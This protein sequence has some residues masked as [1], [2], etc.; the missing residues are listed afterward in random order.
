MKLP[1]L[2]TV[3][4]G[5]EAFAELWQSATAAG[6]RLGWLDMEGPVDA[7]AP[8]A[9][10]TGLGAAKAVSAHGRQTVAVK[11]LAGEPVLRDLVREHFLGCAAL[12]V[13]GRA[14]FPRLEVR[15]GG[16]GVIAMEGAPPLWLDPE[17]FL[18]R[19]RRPRLRG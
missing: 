19:L 13:R 16:L 12:L 4:A 18:A 17:A 15:P 8:L 11:R 5:P 1:H 9:G 14:G 10:A 3:E 7:P 6:L 2:Y